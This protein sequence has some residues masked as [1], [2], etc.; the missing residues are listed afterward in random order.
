MRVLFTVTPGLGHVHPLV[1]FASAA[2]AAGHDV[3]F[4]TGAGLVGVVEGSG[5]ACFPTGSD[6]VD[7]DRVYPQMVGKVGK[8]R[9]ALHWQYL[10]AGHYPKALIGGL[11]ELAQT[12]RPDIIVRDDVNFGG[13]VAAERLGIPH[14]AVQTVAFRPHLYELVREL[15]DDRRREAGLAADA[16]G[17]MPFRHLFLSPFPPSYLNPDVALPSTT[18]SVRPVPFDRSGG[19]TLP[20]WVDQLSGRPLVYLTLGTVYNHRADVFSAFIE[21]LR[22]EPVELVVTVGRDQDPAQYGPQPP[23]VHVERYVPQ[24]LLFPRC[25]LVVSHGGSGT[26]MAALANGLPM[27]VVPIA[28]DQPENA[29]RCAALGVARVLPAADLSAEAARA[30]VLDVLADRSYRRSAS[31]L[32]DEI[33]ALPGPELAVGLL[34]ALVARPSNPTRGPS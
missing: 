32:R 5:F 13:C 28:A 2:S 18:R 4:A 22:D 20:D 16:E 7:A 27:V 10:F 14:A 9:A 23:N 12:W 3:A 21:G 26:I 31:D 6:T 15:L 1:P 30:A 17:M 19:D 34:E 8:E 24:T 11:V 33:T 25:A 29:E